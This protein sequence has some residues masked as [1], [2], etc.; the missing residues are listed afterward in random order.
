VQLGSNSSE[1]K[2]SGK[3]E[4][5]KS[6]NEVDYSNSFFSVLLVLG[7]VIKHL[8]KSLL[9]SS[10]KRGQSSLVYFYLHTPFAFKNVRLVVS[11]DI[12]LLN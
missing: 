5:H 9:S 7:F 8:I 12:L 6:V 11:N 4:L 3:P 10:I 2:V 1:S